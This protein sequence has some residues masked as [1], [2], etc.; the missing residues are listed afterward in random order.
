[1]CNTVVFQTQMHLYRHLFLNRE[2]HETNENTKRKRNPAARQ[3]ISC[4]HYK[5]L[6]YC[7][8][9][10]L[11]R[12]QW[13]L[14]RFAKPQNAF[15]VGRKRRKRT[16]MKW[17]K[18]KKITHTHTEKEEM[19]RKEMQFVCV[20]AFLNASCS[21]ACMICTILQRNLMWKCIELV[22]RCVRLAT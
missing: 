19:K 14:L 21:S 9:I 10:V 15:C 12:L 7:K 6:V 4:F 5:T 18:I 13:R 11:W 1:M 17:N 22:G 20:A 8:I 3:K 2:T 16:K